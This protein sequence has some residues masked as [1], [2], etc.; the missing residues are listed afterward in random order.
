MKIELT[1]KSLIEALILVLLSVKVTLFDNNFNTISLA[2]IQLSLFTYITSFGYTLNKIIR[3]ISISTVDL[4]KIV[5]LLYPNTPFFKDLPHL[6]VTSIKFYAEIATDVTLIICFIYCLFTDDNEKSASENNHNY[7]EDI[8][9]ILMIKY[10]LYALLFSLIVLLNTQSNSLLIKIINLT[11]LLFFGITLVYAVRDPF[12]LIDNFT[13]YYGISLMFLNSYLYYL[14]LQKLT[15]EKNV[16]A[17]L[18][19]FTFFIQMIIYLICCF[20][21]KYNSASLNSD[22]ILSVLG[23]DSSYSFR[24]QNKKATKRHIYTVVKDLLYSDISLIVLNIIGKILYFIWICF[25]INII[26]CVSLIFVLTYDKKANLIQYITF[27]FLSLDFALFIIRSVLLIN[28]VHFPNILTTYY[29]LSST[30]SLGTYQVE[31]FI[32]LSII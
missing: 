30:E 23:S 9:N 3:L 2:L 13:F 29:I 6:E 7:K 1:T 19:Y 26:K 22:E 14:Y 20:I 11:F 25:D 4:V 16:N 21:I 27:S 28:N 31:I 18:D 8:Q 10:I 24:K 5:I 32:A 12:A 17:N 15:I